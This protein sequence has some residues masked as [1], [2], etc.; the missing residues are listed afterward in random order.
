MGIDRSDAMLYRARNR[1]E[2]FTKLIHGT[3]DHHS[4]K[5]GT[6]DMIIASYSLTMMEDK[7]EILDAIRHHLK[8]GGHLLVVDFAG[9]R[10]P[11]FRRWMLMNHVDLGY[12][13]FNQLSERFDSTDS[14]RRSA[15]GGLYHYQIFLGRS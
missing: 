7:A 3:Y 12:P 14:V 2:S 5:S 8:P 9:S 1:A 10:Y 11:G 13:L 6:F 15:W 4:F